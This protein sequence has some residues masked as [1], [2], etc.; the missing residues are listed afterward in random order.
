MQAEIE[1]ANSRLF[2]ARNA[3]A[4]KTLDINAQFDDLRDEL[5]NE[6]DE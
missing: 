2:D 1:D 4:S 6:L 5:E 3:Q